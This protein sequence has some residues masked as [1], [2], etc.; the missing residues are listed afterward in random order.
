MLDHHGGF[1][2]NH[3]LQVFVW[4]QHHHKA[5]RS[6]WRVQEEIKF[7]QKSKKVYQMEH[8]KKIQDYDECICKFWPVWLS[9]NS[10]TEI[11]PIVTF[12]KL[13]HY[14]STICSPEISKTR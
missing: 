11:M 8:S 14:S 6:R 12:G 10:R 4:N 5:K 13:M 9:K 2:V 1:C 3:R 7:E